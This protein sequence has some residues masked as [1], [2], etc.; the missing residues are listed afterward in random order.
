MTIRFSSC[1]MVLAVGVWAASG[2]RGAGDAGAGY[3]VAKVIHVGGEGRWD[4]VTIDPRTKMLYVPRQTHTQVVNAQTG[5]IVG[6]LKETPGVHGV[7]LAPE[8]DR[9][10][11]SNG[12]GKSVTVFELKTLKVLGTV[13]AGEGPDAIIY[14]PASKKVL[15]MNG[16]SHDVTVIDASAEPGAAAAIARVPLDGKPEFAAADGKG[17][18]YVNLEDKSSVAVI[19][20]NAWK[21]SE[22]WKIEGGEEPS[23]LAI[24]AANGRLF[25]GCGNQVMA[26][27]DTHTGKTLAT[28][29]IGNGVDACGFD[30]DSGEAFASCGDGSLTVAKETAP[31]KFE[32]VQKVPTRRGARTMT[33][34]PTTHT[35]Y[36]PTAEFDDA[37]P[38]QRRPP[39]KPGTFMIVVVSK[40]AE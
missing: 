32:V 28:L 16:R 18:V 7:A 40:Q 8:F 37:A 9:G 1:L 17:H 10:F 6:D 27:L 21:V 3:H 30:P 23:G 25:A 13:P 35:V 38:G 31:G 14:D 36:L 39:M 26:I 20:T 34:D 19:D 15:A 2:A 22:V 4:Y 33:V 29:P 5:A 24:D 12:Q 11:T